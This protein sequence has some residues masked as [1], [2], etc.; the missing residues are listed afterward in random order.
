MATLDQ[1]KALFPD[2]RSD[3][4]LI[5][6]AASEFGISPADI[7]AEVGVKI[8]TPGFGT[9]VKRGIGQV[10]S[11]LG[12]TARDLGL[13]RAGRALEA[14]GEDVAFRNPAA[15][16]TVSEAISSPWQTTKEALGE[17]VPQIGVSGATA[18]GGRAL[19]GL[20][21]IPFGPA[22]V[23]AG[24]AVGG[25]AG[26]YLGNLAQEYGGIRSEQR[27]SGKEDKTRALGA[28]AA[29]AVLDTAVGVERLVNKVGNKGL[30]ILSREAG[31]KL[32]PHVIKQTG[33]GIATEAGTETAQTALERYGAFKDLT[34]ADA[35]NEYGMAAIKGGIGGGVVRGGLSAIAGERT[36][37]IPDTDQGATPTA[38]G[39]PANDI[40]QTFQANDRTTPDTIMA[41]LVGRAADPLAGRSALVGQ[42]AAP[43]V[44]GGE[45]E[46][47]Q[48]QQQAQAESQQI[49][50]AQAQQA[51]REQIYTEYGIADPQ[52][53][54]KGNLFGKPLF[55]R[56]VPA[57]ADAIG[58][59]TQTM[60]PYQL[61]LAQAVNQANTETGGKLLNFQFNAN[62]PA[63]SVQKA[64][65]AV[66]KV[67]VGFQIADAQSTTEA[68]QIL[69]EQSK[70][71]TGTKL[72]Q[73]NAIHY[74]LTGEDTVGFTEAQ[75]S[76]AAK[77]A[78]DGKL[79]LQDNAG[80]RNVPVQG[81]TG[82][83]TDGGDGNVRPTQVQPVGATGLGEGS[84]GLQVGQLPT[85][86]I[87]AGTSADTSVG[88]GQPTPNTQVIGAPN[89][90]T[91]AIVG[92]GQVSGEQ[93]QAP[94]AQVGGQS[95]QAG[96][97]IYATPPSYY[98]T[99]LS[100]IQSE[101]R[102]N[103]ILDLLT[104]VLKPQ[105]ERKNTVPAETR[106]E[107][108]RLALM[109]QMPH[110]TI[111]EVTGL[112]VD[113]V[114]KQLE[115]MGVKLQDGE[116]QVVDPALA[117]SVAN[118]AA[119][120]R[121]PEFPDGIGEGELMA[122]YT[123]RYEGEDAPTQ[124][125]ADEFEQEA[126]P[127]AKLQEELRGKDEGEGKTMGV[128][129]T[130]GGSQGA[131]EGTDDAFF[132]KV[133]KLQAMLDMASDAD[134]P[135][136]Q[137]QLDAAWAQYGKK[138]TKRIEA[139]RLEEVEGEEDAVQEPSTEE[140]PVRKRAR[141]GKAVGE[142]NAK[143]GKAAAKSSEQK[144]EHRVTFEGKAATLTIVRNKATPEKVE[145]VTVRVDGSRLA[146]LNLGPQGVVSD[147]KLIA[148]LVATESIDSAVEPKQEVVVQTPEEQWS[149]LAEQFPGMPPYES[150]TKDEKIRWDDLASR[151]VANLAA[152]NKI[153][154]SAV[155]AGPVE[156]PR[157]GGAT[158]AVENVERFTGDPA[159]YATEERLPSLSR[160]ITALRKQLDAGEITPE[161]FAAR[162]ELLHNQTMAAKE[163]KRRP[164]RMRGHLY[165]R[166]RLMA[167]AR[168]GE[169]DEYGVAMADWF[170]RQKV[171]LFDDLGISI[172][173]PKE[174]GGSGFYDVAR[175]VVNLFK[176]SNNTDTAVHELLHHLERMMPDQ[177][178]NAIRKAWLQ[179]LATAAKKASKSGDAA[180]QA[181]YNDLLD[182]HLG[183]TEGSESSGRF[184]LNAIDAKNR[185]LDAV[186]NGTVG[187]EHYQHFTPSEF[188]AVN[189]ADLVAGRFVAARSVVGQ[190]KQWLKELLAKVKD[191][192]GAQSNAAIIRALDSVM[193]GNGKFMPAQQ[194]I[195]EG[196]EYNTFGG[197][198]AEIG[199]GKRASLVSAM[200][201]AANGVD[202]RTIWNQTGWYKASD[203]NWRFEIDDS[204]AKF[205]GVL[206]NVKFR[207]VARMQETTLG[208]ILD[209]DELFEAYPEL[210]NVRFEVRPIPLDIFRATQGW[211]DDKLNKLFVT[212][213]AQDPLSTTL[214]EIQHWI[215]GREG[216]E[217]GAS[218]NT[219]DMSNTA[220]LKKI[221]AQFQLAITRM[222]EKAAE[223]VEARKQGKY[224]SIF[225]EIVEAERA[226]EMLQAI[227]QLLDHNSELKPLYEKMRSLD[228]EIDRLT[229][230]R[231]VLQEKYKEANKKVNIAKKLIDY[232][233]QQKELNFYADKARAATNERDDVNSSIKKLVRQYTGGTDVA[234]EMYRLV[235][236]E[237]EAR[238]TQARRGMEYAERTTTFPE[239]T[240]D[241]SPSNLL[242]S[243][244]RGGA[245]MNIE[246][247]T[248]EPARPTGMF[249]KAGSWL[250][251]ML[252]NPKQ[253]YQELK[254]GFLTLEQLAELDKS[255]TQ[256]VRAYADV[257]T[258]MQMTSK[259]LVERAAQIDQL[260]SKLDAET[261]KRLSNVMRQATRMSF[262]PDT[263]VEEDGKELTPEQSAL[264]SEF[265]TLPSKAQEVYRRVRDHYAASF[266]MRKA[267]MEDV[268]ARLGGKELKEIQ[269][270]YSKVKG[271]YFPLGRTGDF[272]AVGMSPRVAELMD[273]K[274]AGTLDRKEAAEL[275][276][277]RKQ[278]S[279][280]QAS[281]HSTLAEAQQAA[282]QYRN[283]LGTGYA[284]KKSERIS[285]RISSMPNFSNME[286][287]I[288]TQLGGETRTEVRSMLTQMMFDMLPEHHALKNQMKREGI[289]GENEDMRQVF[290]QTSINQAHYISRLQHSEQLNQA[291]LAIGRQARRDLEMRNLENELKL[292]T[293]MSME[294]T[295]S[296]VVDA[297]VNASYFAHLGLSPAFLLT[298][299]TQVPM[300]TA[301]WLGARH[302]VGA[303]KR[304]MASSLA[305]TAKIIKTTYAN[306]DWRSELNWN[307]MFPEGSNEDRMF[308]ALLDR[309]VL[310]ITMEHDLAA[311]ASANRGFFDDNIAK[312]SKG[313]L[314]GMSDVVRMVNT[315]VRITELANRAVTA[316][317]A[318]RLKMA[319]LASNTAMTPE[320][321]HEAS[322]SY[323][324][325]A[326]SE[327]Q[328]NYSELN[329]PRHMR[330]VFGSKAIAKMVFQFRKYQ[331]GML[332]LVAKSISDSL[333]GSK[334][335]DEDRRIA[336]RTIAGL[337]ITTG[338]MAGTTGMPLMGTVGLAGIANLIAAAFG[339][340]DEPWDFETEYRNFLTDWFGR[341]AALLLAK[342]LPAY[343]G[344][345]L[346]Q[347]VGM[348]ELAN[349]IPFVQRGATGASTVANVLYAA[350]GAPVGMIG[351][352]YDGLVAMANGDTLK[353]VEKIIPV[354]MMKD[355]L[356]MYRYTDE[357][358]TDRRGNVILPP[359][360]F[361]TIDLALRGMGF[362]PTIESEYYAANEA[363]QSAKTAATDV[364]TRLI[365]QYSEARMR[366][367]PVDDIRQDIAQFNQRHPEQSVR[368]TESTLLKAL[369]ARRQM[370][371]QRNE[372]GV[373][374]SKA[375]KPFADRARFA[376][377]NEE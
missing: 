373:R 238:N 374:I 242:T 355:A 219:V 309:N 212:P 95:V 277:L 151:G 31:E 325:R 146:E 224:I 172:R 19:G 303:T 290:A 64:F 52:N 115:R 26:A 74:A 156:T 271:P 377:A 285:D 184:S 10:E 302:G 318:Y 357:G 221:Q 282:A 104:T 179:S 361:D 128:V 351:T 99:D 93:Q 149:A 135:N 268:G 295:N 48:A 40:S 180:L 192:F 59:A 49:Q 200:L 24:Q 261:S 77:G 175:R 328:L 44:A 8:S 119:N 65:E 278:K 117:V 68:A 18:L 185:A 293:K 248:K 177:V 245:Y 163:S 349:P 240:M 274:D 39:A 376:T 239:E 152:A 167:A 193:K 308:R 249:T 198:K 340:E 122:L 103:I 323:A 204:G 227:Q 111:A 304:A 131:V 97:R 71:L 213:Y 105:Q 284:N 16:N 130:A 60:T 208:E 153:L 375:E 76:K 203:G 237:A 55:G 258:A 133:G 61:E 333:P 267:I 2:A 246:R 169:L 124:S 43:A 129:A 42:V 54:T 29:A 319:A 165:I 114:E 5:K 372:A 305:D 85:E 157:A 6:Q 310:D 174:D 345:D 314:Q 92:G 367:E 205:K 331:Q 37:L 86:G 41:G 13:E 307:S 32:A 53:P 287:Y 234:H 352:M 346:S 334:A 30:N 72:E 255:P 139:N 280:Y 51:R 269:D 69:N 326:V 347:R 57:V 106:A 116:F 366:G 195:Y 170:I 12:S 365:R 330:Q 25:T 332:Y 100:H 50:A 144:T 223:Q 262:D 217:N 176:G 196:G 222:E 306:G 138:Q 327:T 272:Y 300:V 17:L 216:F 312:A 113:T 266:E 317:S 313:K 291:M 369:N 88:D 112:K 118:A 229:T 87:R 252:T 296:P 191:V 338:L 199:E 289:Y 228:T 11:A 335:S 67:A 98:A 315:P 183:L 189:A 344:A 94:A 155:K 28:G 197:Q 45:T 232:A 321:R 320:Q 360:K 350:G 233:G 46:I 83:A 126:K 337:Y 182:Y 368:I 209:H 158:E 141:G 166:E 90:A 136:V 210:R 207:E 215:Q 150:L 159:A 220:A 23:A 75:Q 316:L 186:K 356:R 168:K 206:A 107:L 362:T 324:A 270:M 273:K 47:A 36:S 9:S 70:A 79:Q 171:S 348:A 281:A 322:V 120:Y 364:R 190:I 34:G 257:A 78:K 125:M 62:D 80:L 143:G 58:T 353:G 101:R 109:E 66:G 286:E 283:T 218:P 82:K 343:L 56:A 140:V 241:V 181:Y 22:G 371:A 264:R 201:D 247:V 342:G 147:E 188:W 148:N 73:L 154:G 142:G 336:R 214:H 339:E 121:S 160:G 256:V 279:Q 7:A 4:D 194:M 370:A 187:Y 250:D 27:E 276:R 263:Y 225:D 35:L 231:K 243:T 260:W 145:A 127:E 108:L 363:V 173:Q 14:Y 254:L 354:K 311:I 33:L 134:K 235:A 259:R 341:D 102:V 110:K 21:G 358:L 132:A 230:A 84:L 91:Q 359:E 20:A 301:P 1:L 164:L 63:K 81:G 253:A 292:R 329:A 137:K 288:N 211:F 3:S 123:T 265:E 96:P 161:A 178:Q 297:M 226:K 236:G 251:T 38:Q 162:V 275:S 299:L 15:V 244:G 298:N 294:Q 89:E 202:P